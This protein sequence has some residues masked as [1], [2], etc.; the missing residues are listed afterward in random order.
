MDDDVIEDEASAV[1]A[2]VVH[3]FVKKVQFTSKCDT[4]L[5]TILADCSM[6]GNMI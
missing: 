3:L 1:Q 6:Y 2:S 5:Y 4:S